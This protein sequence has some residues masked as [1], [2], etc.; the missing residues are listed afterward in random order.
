MSRLF[1]TN[2]IGDARR[3][4]PMIYPAIMEYEG[5]ILWNCRGRDVV[6]TRYSYECSLGGLVMA[7]DAQRI[8]CKDNC[9][10]IHRPQ[11]LK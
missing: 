10:H 2:R 5:E 4:V 6:T 9:A 1:L 7:N 11:Y 3:L 8:R